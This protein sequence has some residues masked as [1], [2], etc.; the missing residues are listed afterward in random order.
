MASSSPCSSACS[1]RRAPSSIRSCRR[2]LLT[3][4]QAKT[5]LLDDVVLSD[6]MATQEVERYTFR[7]PG[8]ATAYFYGYIKLLGLREEVEK[9]LGAK[10]NPRA[11]HDFILGQGLL[12]PP[13]LRKAVLAQFHA[14]GRAPQ[15]VRLPTCLPACCSRR[16]RAALRSKSPCPVGTLSAHARV[17]QRN[18]RMNVNRGP[19]REP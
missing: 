5:V 12:P 1:G 9:A 19:Y 13:L 4:A 3:P 8:Q 17:R 14:A 15:V 6:A 11:F 7:S 10:F 16:C 18:G 2:G